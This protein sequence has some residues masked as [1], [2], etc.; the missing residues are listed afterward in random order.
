MG[1]I[2]YFNELTVFLLI[3]TNKVLNNNSEEEVS[4]DTEHQ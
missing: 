4:S 2:K 1:G 3:K